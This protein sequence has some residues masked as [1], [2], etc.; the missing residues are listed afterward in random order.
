MDAYELRAYEFLGHWTIVA[1]RVWEPEPGCV[2]RSLI[3]R[4]EHT[5]IDEEDPT[6]RAALLFGQASA[7]LSWAVSQDDR[8]SLEKSAQTRD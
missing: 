3:Y 1:I 8:I 6:I 4:S 7:D 5:P 2:E